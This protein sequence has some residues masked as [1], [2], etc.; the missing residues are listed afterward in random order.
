MAVRR[1]SQ[2]R[3]RVLSNVHIDADWLDKAMEQA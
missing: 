1:L 3:S 2:M